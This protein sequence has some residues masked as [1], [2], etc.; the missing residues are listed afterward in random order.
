MH[1]EVPIFIKVENREVLSKG[2]A[3][4]IEEA[5]H[6][7][8]LV[9]G[10]KLPSEA[11]LSLQFGVSRTAI[12]EAIRMVSAKGLLRIEK[13][14]GIYVKELSADSVTD[15]IHLYLQTNIDENYALDII[16]SRQI[17][18]PS[19]AADAARHRTD[20]DIVRLRRDI[21]LLVA[22]TGHN[23]GLAQMDM[24]FHLHIARATQNTLIPLMLE[25]IHRLMPAIKKSVYKA[26]DNA[27]DSAVEWHGKIVEEIIAGSP[28][29]AFEAMK[30]HREIA[31][32]HVKTALHHES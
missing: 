9:I 6:T 16:H 29:G 4:Q 20:E 25:P 28:Q 2:I 8:K 31:E 5:I 18:E 22:Y 12:R 19:I 30:H 10:T 11:E 7:K 14:K 32:E 27:K 26:I 24:D 17:I 21:E 13:G 3:R 15:P 1:P 23:D